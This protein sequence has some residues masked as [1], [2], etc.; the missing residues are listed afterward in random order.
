MNIGGLGSE[1]GV[2][3]CAVV[4]MSM[5]EEVPRCRQR[6]TNL[7]TPRPHTFA[8]PHPLQQNEPTNPNREKE[9]SRLSKKKNIHRKTIP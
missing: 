6:K 4:V 3:W 7:E 8:M 9:V 1:N 2:I 5:L